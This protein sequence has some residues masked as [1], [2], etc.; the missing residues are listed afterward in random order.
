[1][2]GG[3]SRPRGSQAAGLT[4]PRGRQLG[5]RPRF[6]AE[7]TGRR[8][9]A[10]APAPVSTSHF[11]GSPRLCFRPEAWGPGW[12]C[13]AGRGRWPRGGRVPSGPWAALGAWRREDGAAA[14]GGLGP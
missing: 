12:V 3:V 10:E 2:C 14:W 8:Q 9:G 4:D 6:P 5:R 11:G 13:E 1:M 7:P